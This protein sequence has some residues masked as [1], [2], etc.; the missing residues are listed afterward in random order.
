MTQTGRR[1]R[2]EVQGTQLTAT[3]GE[4]G[5]RLDGDERTIPITD[6][7]PLRSFTGTLPDGSRIPIYVE[8]GENEHE[9]TVY[10]AGQAVP[11]RV[12]T[13]RD[14]RLL[15]LRKNTAQGSSAA[16]MLSAPMPGLL[17][18]ILV[19]EGDIVEKGRALCILEAMKME[20]EI[21]SPGRFR[22]RRVIAQ[23]GAAVEKGTRLLELEPPDNADATN[24]Q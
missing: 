9:Y 11:V 22:V 6:D 10:L 5:V 3:S 24:V 21:K 4:E 23:A 2:V 14:E 8:E 20:N 18:E 1:Y 7:A 12:V 16:Q 19:D 15:A 17:K 13:A